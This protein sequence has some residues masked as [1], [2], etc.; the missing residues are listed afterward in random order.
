[1]KMILQIAW[2]NLLRNKRRTFLSALTIAVGIMYFAMMD[3][4]MTGMDKSAI[5][6]MIDLST[7]A[8][9]IQ[10][11]EYEAEQESFPLEYGVE[12]REKSITEMLRSDERV[13]GITTR[14]VFLGQLS[15]YEDMFPVRGIVIDRETDSTVF[16]V[17]E[18]I[19]GEY[20]GKSSQSEI[21]LGGALAKDLGVGVGD[22]ITLYAQTK[23]ETQNADDFTIVGLVNSGDPGINSN[24]IFISKEAGDEFLDLEGFASELNVSLHDRNTFNELLA[25]MTEIQGELQKAFPDDT[26]LTFNETGADFIQMSK[27]KS[28]FGYIMLTVILFIAA[29]GIFNTVLMSVYERIRE[30]GVL[31]AHGMKP[32]DL[33]KMFMLEG[34]FTGVLGGILGFF[35]AVGVV[36]LFVEYG[37]NYE[38]MAEGMDLSNLPIGGIIYGVWNI[39]QVIGAGIFSTIIATVAAVIPAKKA[40]KMSV[41]DAL[42]FN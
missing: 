41:T 22:M 39:P 11:R 13:R 25:D 12:K 42:R 26:I 23:Y 20:L 38:K 16:T 31:R 2:R 4:L 40:G 35:L 32:K 10:S 15:N 18:Y 37:M 7:G 24:T 1:M 33:V 8:V 29:V 3:S 28:G 36:Y 14:A 5:D 9:K 21:L 27:S 17:D 34:F 19:D 30:I 6:N